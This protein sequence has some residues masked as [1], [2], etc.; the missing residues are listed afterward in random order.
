MAGSIRRTSEQRRHGYMR[1]RAKV[2]CAWWYC[3]PRVATSFEFYGGIKVKKKVLT[4]A[5]FLVFAAAAHGQTVQFGTLNSAASISGASVGSTGGS[6]SNPS[7]LS[8]N[9]PSTENISAT[10]PGEYIPSRF[11]VYADAV[12]DGEAMKNRRAMTIAEMARQSQAE[13]KAAEGKKVVVLDQDS[14]GKLTIAQPTA[15]VPAVAPAGA[16]TVSTPAAPAAA[17]P[18]GEPAPAAAPAATTA[19]APAPAKRGMELDARQ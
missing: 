8:G 19:P 11:E 12:Q 2:L 3:V 10:N 7:G 15:A 18:A 1:P 14:N 17:T 6:N 9:A 13:K 16:P 5:A 4:T